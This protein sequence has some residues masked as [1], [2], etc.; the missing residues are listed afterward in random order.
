M[1]PED[2]PDQLVAKIRRLPPERW[3]PLSTLSIFWR[4]AKKIDG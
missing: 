1:S 4:S 2:S 3:R